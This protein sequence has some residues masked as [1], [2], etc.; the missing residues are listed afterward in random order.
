MSL[1]I[2]SCKTPE[3]NGKLYSG[4]SEFSRIYRENDNGNG[5]V[6]IYAD[7]PEFDNYVCTSYED[8]DKLIKIIHACKKW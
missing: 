7:S 6:S 1:A 3:W 2:T 5:G 4:D 8:L